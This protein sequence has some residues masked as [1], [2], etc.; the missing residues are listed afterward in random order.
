MMKIVFSYFPI[1][2]LK[3]EHRHEDRSQRRRLGAEIN[4]VSFDQ[5]SL[6]IDQQSLVLE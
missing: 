6:T 3:D 4:F 1:Q 5:P 2:F